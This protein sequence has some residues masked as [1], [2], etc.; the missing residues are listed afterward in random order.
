[1]TKASYASSKSSGAR[2]LLRL[3]WRERGLLVESLFWLAT[4]R[5]IV[6]LLPFQ[7]LSK[8][9]GVHMGESARDDDPRVHQLIRQ[10][11]WAILAVSRR[12]P[13]RCRCLEQG[14]AAKMMLRRRGVGNTLYL[15]VARGTAGVEAHAWLRNGSY[16]LT[17][18]AERERF[19]V[20]SHFADGP[21]A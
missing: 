18:G 16:Y 8:A 10:I 6:L 19:A 20:V 13:W 4:A 7:V 9:L 14:I 1:V 3:S 17:G 15:G 21:S 11:S 2:T 5:L 12:A